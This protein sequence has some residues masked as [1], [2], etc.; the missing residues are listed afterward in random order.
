MPETEAII[1]PDRRFFAISAATVADVML[2]I[3]LVL[4]V[5]EKDVP[6]P[7]F[8]IV[9]LY[10][11]PAARAME[12]STDDPFPSAPSKASN[13]NVICSPV[14]VMLFSINPFS[15]TSVAL[16]SVEVFDPAVVV[17]ENEPPAFNFT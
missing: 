15:K 10:S 11:P 17:K 12:P 16:E 7:V 9:N 8:G 14:G 4:T 6:V 5:D 1:E 2:S 13:F 3:S